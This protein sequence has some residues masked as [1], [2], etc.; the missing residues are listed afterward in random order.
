MTDQLGVY[1]DVMT[2]IKNDDKALYNFINQ[3]AE[4]S[5]ISSAQVLKNLMM[6]G[7][8]NVLK[9]PANGTHL[10]DNIQYKDVKADLTSAKRLKIQ[11]Y[12]RI[13]SLISNTYS[14]HQDELTQLLKESNEDSIAQILAQHPTLDAKIRRA[15]EIAKRYR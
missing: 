15:R 12:A 7:L 6:L 11:A 14:R 10:S 5:D 13:G 4:K 1:I 9:Y 8:K 2:A 3:I